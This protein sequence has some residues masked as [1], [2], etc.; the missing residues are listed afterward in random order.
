MAESDHYQDGKTASSTT[1]NEGNPLHCPHPRFSID[2]SQPHRFLT[3]L[4]ARLFDNPFLGLLWSIF[5]FFSNSSL[6]NLHLDL[7]LKLGLLR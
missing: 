7:L 6:S 2:T 5:W 4:R 1:A 3:F